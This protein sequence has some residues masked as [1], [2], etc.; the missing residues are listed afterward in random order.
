VPLSKIQTDVLRLLAFHRDPESYVARAT[1]LNRDASRYSADIDVFHD[2][3]ERVAAA[4]LDDAQVLAAA[5][6]QVRW[7]RQLPLIYTAEV[8]HEDAATRL[9]WIVDSD[10]RFFPTMR[11]ETFGYMLHPV[12]LATN[13][14]M[15]AA[16][17]REVRDLVDLVTVHETIL[18]LGAV[19]WAAVEKSPGFTPE[20][21]IAEIRRNAN[22]PAADWRAL[23]S[24]QPIDPRD[25][26]LRLRSALGEA[27]TF[28]TRMPT[29]KM[30]VLFLKDGQVVQPDPDRLPDYRTHAGQRRGQW[31]SSPEITAAMF[32]R[33]KKPPAP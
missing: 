10:F 16:G 25:I 13:K 31:P 20:G 1:P 14:V 24:S 4:A 23:S 26:T 18:S 15:A 19:I 29:E 9:E 28:A 22:Y 8:I 3:E 30:G 11:D 33:Y 2:R 6:Y 21:L 17:R 5:G 27:E 32:E 7:L 12:D